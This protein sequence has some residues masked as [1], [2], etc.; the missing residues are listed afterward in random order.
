MVPVN[1]QYRAKDL[2]YVLHDAGASLL[3]ADPGFVPAIDDIRRQL[4]ELREVITLA[5]GAVAASIHSESG[6]GHPRPSGRPEVGPDDLLN[7]QY[8]S[9][10]TGEPKGC[11][12]THEYWLLLAERAATFARMRPG[13]VAIT[14]QPFYYMD[15]QWNVAMCIASGASLVMLPRFSASTFWRS[16]AECGATFTYVLGAMPV[17]LLRQPPDPAVERGHRLRFVACSGIVPSLHAEFEA[18]WGVPWREVFG[19]TETG[20][21]LMVPVE[22]ASSVGTGAMG[23]PIPGKEAC[24]MDENG[25]LLGD[26]EVGELCLR[27]RGLMRGYWNKPEA[28]AERVRDGWLHTGDLVVRRT[29][30]YYHMVGRLKDMIRRGGENI[31]ATEVEGVLAEH[32]AVRAAAVVAVPDDLRGEEVKAF[33]QLQPGTAHDPAAVVAF[34]QQRIAAFKAPR[35]VAFVNDFPRTPSER[36]AKHRLQTPGADP[37]LGAWDAL[38]GQWQ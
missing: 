10:T 3:I 8:T 22:D 18:R 34:V 33:I 24:V 19:M 11:M 27:G 38:T 12:L 5:P 23:R 28:T 15:P 1:T 35:Y 31:S 2:Q 36:I 25:H 7:I 37:R 9:G 6:A 13:E 16:V 30:G 4:P 21:D 26:D 14:A 32:P 20:A 17:F 29:T